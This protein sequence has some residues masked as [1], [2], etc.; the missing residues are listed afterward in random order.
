METLFSFNLSLREPPSISSSLA[1]S[2][3]I[4]WLPQPIYGPHGRREQRRQKGIFVI[5]SAGSSRI[6]RFGLRRHS[7]ISRGF[8]ASSL[9]AGASH[10]QAQHGPLRVRATRMVRMVMVMVMMVRMMMTARR[11]SLL[12]S[13]TGE[14]E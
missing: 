2:V 9:L 1:R 4:V 5:I 6:W 13:C 12:H 3:R 7:P 10:Q 14:D 8:F 11:L